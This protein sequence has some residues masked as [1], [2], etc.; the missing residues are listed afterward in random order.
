MLLETFSLETLIVIIK[1]KKKNCNVR[2]VF[3][4]VTKVQHYYSL[5]VV[6]DKPYFVFTL[7]FYRMIYSPSQGKY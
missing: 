1:K 3:M 2:L 7:C 6:P 5:K 4:E